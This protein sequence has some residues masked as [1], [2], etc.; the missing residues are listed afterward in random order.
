MYT[1]SLHTLLYQSNGGLCEW[2]YV[3]MFIMNRMIPIFEYTV[4]QCVIEKRIRYKV[5][6]CSPLMIHGRQT[7]SSKISFRWFEHTRSHLKHGSIIS[8]E[9]KVPEVHRQREQL[10]LTWRGDTGSFHSFNCC[11]VGTRRPKWRPIT[12][13]AAEWGVIYFRPSSSSTLLNN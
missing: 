9:E 8:I 1:T 3:N 10:I 5:P 4:G 13:L 7:F 6:N 11:W 12:E 2:R